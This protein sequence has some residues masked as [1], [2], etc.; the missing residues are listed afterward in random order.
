MD[1]KEGENLRLTAFGMLIALMNRDSKLSTLQEYL[2]TEKHC[3]SVSLQVSRKKN[4][5]MRLTYGARLAGRADSAK[6][7]N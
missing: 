3:Q 5:S 4:S 6:K 1:K 7:K 2:E